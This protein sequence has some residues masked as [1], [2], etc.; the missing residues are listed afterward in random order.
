[1]VLMD[2]KKKERV[3][4]N[5]AVLWYHVKGLNEVTSFEIMTN[6]LVAV[7]VD[8]GIDWNDIM[9]AAKTEVIWEAFQ[10]GDL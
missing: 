10:S 7:A 9:A 2:K 1:M 8:L 5:L 3:T 4:Y 6:A